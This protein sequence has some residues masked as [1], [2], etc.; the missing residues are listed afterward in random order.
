VRCS[1]S[2]RDPNWLKSEVP[3]PETSLMQSTT[4]LSV[5]RSKHLPPTNRVSNPQM[6]PSGAG[7]I[8]R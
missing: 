1:E 8:S 3:T 6:P 7:Y 5:N 4:S 2:A